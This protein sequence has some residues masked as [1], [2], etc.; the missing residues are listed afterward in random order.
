[1]TDMIAAEPALAGR[2]LARQGATGSQAA[3]LATA[4]AD[5]IRAGLPVVVTGCGTSEHASLGIADIL[6]EAA[7]RSRPG[8]PRAA[9]R[10]RPS[11]SRSTRR[12][13]GW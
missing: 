11:S 7:R 12:P 8:R 2:I 13:R 5:T 1:M 3:S 4:V 6:R 10:P 9:S